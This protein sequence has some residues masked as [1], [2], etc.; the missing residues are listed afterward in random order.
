MLRMY[1]WIR[2]Y[3][4]DNGV[5]QSTAIYVSSRSLAS[6]VPLLTSSA[7]TKFSNSIP[8]IPAKF[9]WPAHSLISATMSVFEDCS[10]C[11][12]ISLELKRKESCHVCTYSTLPG[13]ERLVVWFEFHV[14]KA[15][16]YSK[17]SLGFTIYHVSP[18]VPIYWQLCAMS[19]Q[20]V[21]QYTS[22]L[23]SKCQTP[24]L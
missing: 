16:F 24:K 19:V 7:C 15:G 5:L 20:A 17:S 14:T 21:C 6:N 18:P 11:S 10:K 13:G 22:A 8:W 9:P 23:C 2:V 4:A 1:S 12:N 3:L